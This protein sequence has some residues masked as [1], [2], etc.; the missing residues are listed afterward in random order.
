MKH[1]SLFLASYSLGVV[2]KSYSEGFKSDSW[3][4]VNSTV[5]A[6]SKN[7]DLRNELKLPIGEVSN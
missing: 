1:H 7:L 4:H 5:M 6:L 3:S 2:K